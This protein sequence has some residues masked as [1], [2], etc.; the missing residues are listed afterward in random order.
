MNL[1]N[2]EMFLMIARFSSINKTAETLFLA[3]STVTHRLKQV[4]KQLGVTLF[5]RTASGVSLT[6]EGR[7]FV[8]VATGIVEQIRAFTQD[9]GT[10]KLLT[11]AA[12]KAFASYELPR[13]LGKYRNKHPDLR[14]YVKSTLFEESIT[15]LLTGTADLALLGSEVYH[16]QLLQLDLPSDRIVLIVAPEHRWARGFGG[17]A[18]WG[19]QEMIMFGDASAP[20]RQRVD[21]F[22]LERGVFPNVIMELDSFS[23]VKQMVIQN[24]GVALLPER[25]IREELATGQLIAHDIAE[26]TLIRPTL[27]AYPKHKAKDRDFQQFLNWIVENYET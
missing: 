25:V 17:F 16:P 8:P 6:P 12:G 23:A 5:I 27:I 26:G 3:Q 15:A 18:D 11:I 10:R 4:E 20:F 19:A 1:D 22:L 13:L 24:L 9:T 2:L 21:R 14:C 7:S